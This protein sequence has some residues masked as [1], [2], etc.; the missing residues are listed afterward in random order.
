MTETTVSR[1]IPPDVKPIRRATAAFTAG[2]AIRGRAGNLFLFPDRIVHVSARGAI[3]VF[4]YLGLLVSRTRAERRARR[5]GM[6]V[7]E[8]PL[9]GITAVRPTRYG[10]SNNMIEID[11]R[12]GGRYRLG[13]KY[14]KWQQTLRDAMAA[15]GLHVSDAGEGL[16]VEAVS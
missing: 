15:Q 7:A 6:G 14:D 1:S 13:V 8:I 11:T 4:G 16:Q 2:A 10:L 12:S 9:A 5:G 3:A